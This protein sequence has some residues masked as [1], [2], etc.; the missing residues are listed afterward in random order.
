MFVI[1]VMNNFNSGNLALIRQNSEKD[2]LIRVANG[3]ERSFRFLFDQYKQKIYSL[4]MYLTHS[5]FLSEE[6]TQEV[7]LKIW[8]YKR[9]LIGVECFTAYLKTIAR[10][11][12][13]NY[14][15]RIANEKIIL[16]QIAVE[17]LQS[18]ETTYHTVLFNEYQSILEKAIQNLPAQQKKVYILS[19]HEGL[20]SEQ[21]AVRMNLSH[22]TVK[23]YMKKALCSI[24]LY[25]GGRIE[26]TMLIAVLH[27]FINW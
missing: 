13:G 8:L 3:D 24:R 9:Q 14:L 6:I 11:V 20:K 25:A 26:L 12:A 18:D 4:S 15:K 23:E 1:F 21:I 17:S 16:Q 7:F 10:H 5:E 27:S 19:R 22:F 2:L